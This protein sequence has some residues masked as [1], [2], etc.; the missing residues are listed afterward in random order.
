MPINIRNV[1]DKEHIYNLGEKILYIVTCFRF[2]THVPLSM[3]V[4]LIGRGHTLS[5]A[6]HGPHPQYVRPFHNS[7]LWHGT[8]IVFDLHEPKSRNEQET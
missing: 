4:S 5:Q 1:F 3:M 7:R 8:N 2:T 6:H